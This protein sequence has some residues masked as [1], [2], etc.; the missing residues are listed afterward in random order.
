MHFNKLV[1]YV[2]L[3]LDNYRQNFF[4]FFLTV[5]EQYKLCCIQKFVDF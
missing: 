4:K 1:S 3:L 5:Q 2:A